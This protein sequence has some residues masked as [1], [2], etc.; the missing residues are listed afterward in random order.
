[1]D[2]T[3]GSLTYT[4]EK[5]DVQTHDLAEVVQTH[6]TVTALGADATT[7]SLFYT[8]EKGD[9]QTHDLAEIVKTH[10]TVT[11]LGT[12]TTTGMLTYLDEEGEAINL[13][14]RALVGKGNLTVSEEMEFYASTDGIGKLLAPASI[15]IVNGGITTAKLANKAVNASKM[16]AE[17]SVAGMV[18]TATGE[19]GKV[20]Y[21]AVPRFFYMPSVI[22]TTST[23]ATGL[24]RDLYQDYVNQFTG[25]AAGAANA[26]YF[27]SHGATGGSMPYSGG[28]IKN[29]GAA[30][31]DIVIYNK[32]QMDYYITYY[33]ASVLANVRLDDNGV[34]TYDII[35]NAKATSYMNIVFV[36]K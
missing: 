17:A 1:M 19:N 26:T 27:I 20:E 25:G 8:D 16:N 7:G 12:N 5:G 28:L 30:S 4:D 13:D 23:L 11:S 3:I 29:P 31:P 24:K 21:K 34:L 32:N 15:R 18:P 14:V 6:E 10:E 33:D 35:G 9:V 2:T 36:I 22:F